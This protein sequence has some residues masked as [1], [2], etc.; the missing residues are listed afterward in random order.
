MTVRLLSEHHLEFLSLEGGCTGS[1]EST[2]VK[3]PHCW[4]S[5]VA[6]QMVLIFS[7]KHLL[8]VCMFGNN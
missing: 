3:M 8:A 6:A 7:L 4:K 2:N 5:H 1:T